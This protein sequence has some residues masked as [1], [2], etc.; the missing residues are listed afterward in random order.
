MR[1]VMPHG[2]RECPVF[3]DHLGKLDA[4]CSENRLQ[5]FP[6]GDP[7]SWVPKMH[8]RAA[9]AT[10]VQLRDVVEEGIEKG[11]RAPSQRARAQ[12]ER[13]RMVQ[14]QLPFGS[15]RSRVDDTDT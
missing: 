7:D 12:K 8:D 4:R 10:R 14:T 15:Q 9:S 5:F 2:D 11:P 3:L 6:T 1:R 13:A